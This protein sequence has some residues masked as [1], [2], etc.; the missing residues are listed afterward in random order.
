MYSCTRLYPHTRVLMYL[1]TC[2]LMYSCTRVLVYS[3]TRV[4]IYSCTHILMYS[5]T[6]VLM[7]V[8]EFMC[9][10]YMTKHMFVLVCVLHVLVHVVYM[11]NIQKS[12]GGPPT[13]CIDDIR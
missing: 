1:C 13:G 4:L 3:Y 11:L 6:H 12:V 2:V 7:S 8:L 5:Y 9:V 10:V